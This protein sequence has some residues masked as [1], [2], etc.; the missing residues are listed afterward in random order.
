MKWISIPQITYWVIIYC[1]YRATAV[2][3]IHDSAITRKF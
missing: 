3:I 2:V 1:Y